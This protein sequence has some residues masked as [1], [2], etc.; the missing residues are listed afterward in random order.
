MSDAG[1]NSLLDQLGP[2][3]HKK[4]RFLFALSVVILALAFA[5]VSQFVF[6]PGAALIFA[7]A[8]AGC[9]A[10]FGL[11][12]GLV[13]AGLAVLAVDF[14][15]IQPIFVLHFDAVTFRAALE[16]VAVAVVTHFIERRISSRIRSKKK[17]PLGIR[18]HLDGMKDGEVY[19]WA[20]DC[21]N[22]SLPVLVTISVDS[23]PVAEVAAVHYRPDI[24]TE[25][26][27]GSHGFY[28]DLGGRISAE[29]EAVVEVR[30]PNGMQLDNSP[31][32][33]RIPSRMR[34][35][36]PAVLFMHI[37]KTAGI[38]FR[39][40][41]TANYRESEIAYLYGT[42][43]GFLTGDLRRL[44]LEQRRS[45]RFVAG[46]FQYGIHHELPQETLYFTI[47]RE[48]A[49]R[50]L[51][52]YAFLQHTQPELLK[53]GGRVLSLEELLER[54]PHVHFD[55]A[56]VRHFGAV[57]ERDFRAGSID[58]QLYDKAVYYLRTGFTFVG[59]QEFAADAYAWLQQ[60]F[61][62]SA[63]PKLEIVN[64]GR[65]RF[66]DARLASIREIF[67][68][69]NRWDSLLYKEILRLFPYA[70]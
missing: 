31:Q 29:K 39:E 9:T 12:A 40:A 33:M 30:T 43:P 23:R 38:A 24:E 22:P 66:D 2:V 42:A 3:R 25:L 65:T 52:H 51:S 5:A 32:R 70:R 20:M 37:P 21:D 34:E 36:G 67:D 48:P 68:S 53:E 61:G 46:H 10:L 19:G 69:Y 15:F 1:L 60:R 54:K 57:D 63:R 17:A 11:A 4:T 44:P 49:A 55:N 62:W 28:V 26:Q 47:V 7:A 45:L 13:G 41:I 64:A 14:F 6:R 59:H 56:L 16:L 35:D 8:V 18:G 58:Q 50:M 27:S